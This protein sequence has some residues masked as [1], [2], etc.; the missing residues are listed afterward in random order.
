MNGKMSGFSMVFLKFRKR[1]RVINHSMQ[2][3]KKNFKKI[4]DQEDIGE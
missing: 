3:Y 4:C 2:T 1:K